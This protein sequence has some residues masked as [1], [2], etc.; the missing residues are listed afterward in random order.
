[1]LGVAD[2]EHRFAFGLLRNR[3]SD[4]DLADRLVREIAAALGFAW[5]AIV[6]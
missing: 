4:V 6:L 1:M 5:P 2:R 3:M